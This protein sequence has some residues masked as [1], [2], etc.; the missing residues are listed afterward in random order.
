M[1]K[2]V[3]ELAFVLKVFNSENNRRHDGDGAGLIDEICKFALV[4]NNRTAL[5]QV[6]ESDKICDRESI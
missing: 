6:C 1:I 5:D 4:S 3:N 2:S